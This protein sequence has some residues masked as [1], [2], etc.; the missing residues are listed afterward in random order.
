MS[1]YRDFLNELPERSLLLL[2][3]HFQLEKNRKQSNEVT[4][5]I[6]LAMP[7]FV[8]SS[9]IIKNG[10]GENEK[11]LN[12]K[13]NQKVE[14]GGIF[15]NISQMWEYELD[16]TKRRLTEIEHLKNPIPLFE[17]KQI[18]L[19]IL[20][21]I[22]NSLSHGE[23]RFTQGNNNNISKILFGLKKERKIKKTNLWN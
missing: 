1:H 18:Q 21:Q 13:L 5:L 22:R 9:E 7:V 14:K 23:I 4:L 6:S 15:Q 3:R 19:S 12:K 20:T 16:D 8:I 11:Q 2:E 10:D 17:S